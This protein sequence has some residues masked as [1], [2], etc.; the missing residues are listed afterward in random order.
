M[1]NQPPPPNFSQ[2]FS[3]RIYTDLK[4]DQNEDLDTD[5]RLDTENMHPCDG[6]PE[7]IGSVR[8]KDLEARGHLA[9]GFPKAGGPTENPVAKMIFFFQK[10]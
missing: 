4:N 5:F 8:N 10:S 1:Q 2:T 7:S 9:T 6:H 3:Q